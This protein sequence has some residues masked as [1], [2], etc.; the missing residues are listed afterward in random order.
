MAGELNGFVKTLT[1]QSYFWHC[2]F[3]CCK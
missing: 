2:Y 1:P 3:V